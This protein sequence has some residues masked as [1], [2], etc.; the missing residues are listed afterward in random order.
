MQSGP[1][2]EQDK[3]LDAMF[4]AQSDAFFAKAYPNESLS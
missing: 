3:R 2:S 1:L 4:R